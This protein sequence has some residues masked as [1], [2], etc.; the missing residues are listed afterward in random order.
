[1]DRNQ[2]LSTENGARSR[3]VTATLRNGVDHVEVLRALFGRGRMLPTTIAVETEKIALGRFVQRSPFVN[4]NLAASAE[5]VLGAIVA[6]LRD[7]EFASKFVTSRLCCGASSASWD[8][9]RSSRRH[10]V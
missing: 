1:M 7:L 3:A 6:R 4:L 2:N 10:Q 5:S 8:R 9:T